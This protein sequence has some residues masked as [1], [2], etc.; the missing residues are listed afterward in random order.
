MI[1][2][3]DVMPGDGWTAAL[4]DQSSSIPPA[5]CRCTGPQ[6]YRCTVTR[7]RQLSQLELVRTIPLG[8]LD[9]AHHFL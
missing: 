6:V 1:V 7:I 5:M 9:C 8:P 3:W 2:A 4:S